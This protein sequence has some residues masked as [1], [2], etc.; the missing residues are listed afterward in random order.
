LHSLSSFGGFNTTEEEA[1]PEFNVVSDEKFDEAIETKLGEL[2]EEV[3]T[4]VDL[5]APRGTSPESKTFA[6]FFASVQA[7][8]RLLDMIFEAVL[9]GVNVKFRKE[10][11]SRWVA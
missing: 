7:T 6:F 1:K 4:W 11:Q 2:L 9:S 8:T 3:A 5:K 10:K